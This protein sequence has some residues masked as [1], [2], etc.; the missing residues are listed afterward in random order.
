MEDD[1]PPGAAAEE[2]PGDLS[3]VDTDDH[4]DESRWPV[5]SAVVTE[6]CLD[7]LLEVTLVRCNSCG[8]TS[9]PT[10]DRVSMSFTVKW[11]RKHRLPS[12]QSFG[13]VIVVFF[14]YC[15]IM[16]VYLGYRCQSYRSIPNFSLH[17]NILAFLWAQ[18]IISKRMNHFLGTSNAQV[19]T[20]KFVI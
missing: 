10:T 20:A 6:T 12:G 8:R 5:R 18:T 2:N 14:F 3:S 4:S 7:T 19:L 13:I 1:L 9:S 17:F 16:T 11:V 15:W